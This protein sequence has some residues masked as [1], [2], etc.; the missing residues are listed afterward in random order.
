MG[1]RDGFDG[2]DEVVLSAEGIQK[3]YTT[4]NGLLDRLLGRGE[5]IRAVDGVD[6]D[7]RAGETLGLVGESGCGKSTLGKVLAGLDEPTE[8]T[9]SYRGAGTTEPPERNRTRRTDVQYVFQNPGASLNPRLPIGEAIGEPLAIHEIVPDERRDERVRELLERVGLDASHA[10]RYPHAFSGGQRQ[11]IAIARALAVEPAV[12]IWDEPVSA[13]DGPVQARILNLLQNLQDD[14]GLSFLFISHDLSVVDHVADRIAVMYL[15]EIV[16]CGSPET[17][18]EDEV[19]PYTEALLSAIPEPD[20]RWEG[21]RIVLEGDVPSATDPPSGCRFHTR[22]PK[23]IPP[24]EY[25][26]DADAF[27]GVMRL[28]T[29]LA[30]VEDEAAFLDT[31]RSQSDGVD[32]IANAVRDVHGIPRTVGDSAAEGV[33]SA[34]LDAVAAGSFDEAKAH[35]GEAFESPCETHRPTLQPQASSRSKTEQHRIAC[36]RFD[37][38]VADYRGADGESAPEHSDEPT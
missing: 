9:V 13:L 10:N 11:R 15:G 36:H 4:A 20:P 5:T 19:H 12:V 33:L 2:A 23:V 22:C 8:G 17:L 35:L 28:R 6:L 32:D 31:V 27:R 26:L 14:L 3:R 1:N 29:R 34:A 37:E 21:D 25:D 30:D 16:E 18:L 24:A 7:L 38:R